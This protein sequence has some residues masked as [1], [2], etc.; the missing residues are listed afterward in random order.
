[1]TC[2]PSYTLK[3]LTCL[4]RCPFCSYQNVKPAGQIKGFAWVYSFCTTKESKTAQ[5]PAVY[6][7]HI[8]FI[9]VPSVESF[10]WYCTVIP[11]LTAQ[12]FNIEKD[13]RVLSRDSWCLP[14][15]HGTGGRAPAPVTISA[16]LCQ[17][18]KF[19]TPQH[20]KKTTP[21]QTWTHRMCELRVIIT[22]SPTH[23]CALLHLD[24]KILAVKWNGE[25][26]V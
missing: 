10:S 24:V 20:C 22:T 11:K 9:C 5:N 6:C 18:K 13:W 7:R 3:H 2:I 23:W 17:P 25:A 15:K 16:H 8:T 14:E 21:K 26:T 12:Y 19:S 4:P 1:M